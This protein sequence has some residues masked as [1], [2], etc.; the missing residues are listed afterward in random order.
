LKTVFSGLIGFFLLGA[1]QSSSEP[2]PTVDLS[3]PTVAVSVALEPWAAA[4]IVA[5]RDELSAAAAPVEFRLE[6]FS[7]STGLE[8]TSEAVAEVLI[9][10][11]DPPED[12]FAAPLGWERIAVIVNPNNPLRS[13]SVSTLQDI[14]LGRVSDWERLEGRAG[15]IQ[16]VIP[17]A[18]DETRTAFGFAVLDQVQ[19]STASRLAPSPQA[20][21]DIVS[22]ERGGIGFVPEMAMQTG[23]SIVRVGGKLPEADNYPLLMQVIAMAPEEPSGAI[24]AWLGWLQLQL[25]EN[26]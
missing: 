11:I 6:A 8:L 23:V 25:T 3:I 1:C 22:E 4:S 17:L 10:G 14:F 26:G 9:A 21:I 20:M 16:P 7:A 5:Y 19:Y 18:G 15:L 2:A 24:R 13:F 12:W